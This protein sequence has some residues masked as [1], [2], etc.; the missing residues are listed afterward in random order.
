MA[1][2]GEHFQDAHIHNTWHEKI[3]SRNVSGGIGSS[4]SEID[5]RHS[6]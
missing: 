4:G 6:G 3:E 1:G 2:H 5:G